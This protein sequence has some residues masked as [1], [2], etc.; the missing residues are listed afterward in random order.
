MVMLVEASKTNLYPE[1]V[2]ILVRTKCCTSLMQEVQCN[3]PATKEYF[4]YFSSHSKWKMY[5]PV[6][7]TGKVTTEWSCS[8][9]LT[10]ASLLSRCI[11]YPGHA[12]SSSVS[13]PLGPPF[14]AKWVGL[15]RGSNIEGASAL[16][17]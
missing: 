5:N 11:H 10:Y 1:Y 13:W 6:L 4:Y 9:L 3:Q 17:V 2:F 8:T 15:E 12:F 7:L 14:G 16:G